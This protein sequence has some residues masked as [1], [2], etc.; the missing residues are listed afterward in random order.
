M[1]QAH[2]VIIRGLNSIIQQAPY[3]ADATDAR[4]SAQDV[5]DLLFFAHSWTKMLQHHHW[6]E[7]TYMFP[8]LEKFA[9]KPGFMDNPKHQHELFHSGVEKFLQYSSATEPENY[10]WH[11]KCGMKEIIDGFA[12]PLTDHLYAEIDT[13][14]A[15]SDLDSD[16]LKK[17]WSRSEDIAKQNGNIAMLVGSA[18][19]VVFPVSIW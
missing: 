15:M 3:V 16:G 8:D 1:A 4:F 18:T 9:G 5:K 7:E 19:H 2:N 6:V 10:R 13:I 14:L 11:G 12:K 17:V